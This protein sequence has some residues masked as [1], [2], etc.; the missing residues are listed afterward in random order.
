MLPC[1]TLVQHDM[2]TPLKVVY[3]VF[4][5]PGQSR[6]L[7]G[8][9]LPNRYLTAA[10]GRRAGPICIQHSPKCPDD[11]HTSAHWRLHP[12]NYITTLATDKHSV[13]SSSEF[14]THLNVP[15]MNS[16]LSSRISK[17]KTLKRKLWTSRHGRK[18]KKGVITLQDI[19]TL[20]RHFIQTTAT[21]KLTIL[22]EHFVPHE[23]MK[24]S[25]SHVALQVATALT[26]HNNNNMINATQGKLEQLTKQQTNKTQ[27]SNKVYSYLNICS[28]YTLYLGNLLRR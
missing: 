25:L 7:W 19:L 3:L 24:F 16:L 27:Q 10:P 21:L 5:I 12:Y 4:G 13:Q 11:G 6:V 18:S 26:P 17:W 22:F 2:C 9:S 1:C 14:Y 20:W 23:I 8:F 28:I 15:I